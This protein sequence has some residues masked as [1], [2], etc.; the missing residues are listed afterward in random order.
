[1]AESSLL[2]GYSWGAISARMCKH[3]HQ[4]FGSAV[5]IGKVAVYLEHDAPD[6]VHLTLV[7]TP[8]P[9]K[10]PDKYSQGVSPRE[11]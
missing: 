2:R 9:T 5:C 4:D 3:G 10:L 8:Q 11:L 6:M 7:W 1:M